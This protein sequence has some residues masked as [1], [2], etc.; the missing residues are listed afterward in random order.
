MTENEKLRALLAE[1]LDQHAHC[2]PCVPDCVWTRIEAALA[3]PV[4][5]CARCE[6]LRDLADKA[7]WAQ[8]DA[9]RRM[10][11][12]QKQRDEAR[13]EAAR[14]TDVL[15]SKHGGE[16]LALLDELDEARAEVAAA[17]QRGA[18]AMREAAL[19]VVADRLRFWREASAAEGGVTTMDDRAEEACAAVNEIRALPIP[20][21]KR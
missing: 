9:Q 4:V 10:I 5:E 21:D 20:E 15:R 18:E 17:Y 14:L 2:L 8:G 12:A 1:A 13:A 3:E 6:T 7:A 19:G 16:P 11:E